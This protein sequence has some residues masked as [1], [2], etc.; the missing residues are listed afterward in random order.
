MLQLISSR[1]ISLLHIWLLSHCRSMTQNRTAAVVHGEAAERKKCDS[2]HYIPSDQSIWTWPTL[3]DI[4]VAAQMQRERTLS[5]FE[6]LLSNTHEQRGQVCTWCKHRC[7]AEVC[8]SVSFFLCLAKDY[9]RVWTKNLNWKMGSC[10][11]HIVRCRCL[12]S[13]IMGTAFL[14]GGK[15]QVFLM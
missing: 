4:P 15:K 10:I 11:S 1:D 9:F 14:L 13:D 7:I 5:C 3:P 12:H 6:R 2:G 8:V